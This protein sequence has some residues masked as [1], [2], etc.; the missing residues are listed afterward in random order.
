MCVKSYENLHPE[1]KEQLT[2]LCNK[3]E[4][5]KEVMKFVKKMCDSGKFNIAYRQK[6]LC[7]AIYRQIPCWHMC[8]PQNFNMLWAY[9]S[10]PGDPRIHLE[11]MLKEGEHVRLI[12]GR[13][14]DSGRPVIIKLYISGYKRS[15]LKS[16]SRTTKM[17]CD[18]YNKLGKPEPCLSTD[19]FIFGIPVL[20]MEVLAE[21]NGGDNEFEMGIQVLQQ[22]K[23]LHQFGVHCDLKPGNVMRKGDKYIVIDY[24]GVAT[25]KMDHGYRR[26]IW[27]PLW[28]SQKRKSETGHDIICTSKQDAIELGYTIKTL[29]NMKRQIPI[30][31]TRDGETDL[32][33]TGFEGKLAKYMKRVFEIDDI[34]GMTDKDRD[35]LIAILKC[36]CESCRKEEIAPIKL[37]VT[38]RPVVPR[39]NIQRDLITPS[40]KK[41]PGRKVQKRIR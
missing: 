6:I 26:W 25:E 19:Y 35:D 23:T 8:I 34:R 40:P 20:V 27:S 28:T 29:Q 17:E 7:Y 36:E 14:G 33:R 21:L 38:P 16:F 15:D 3:Y 18:I 39:V 24:G 32:I 9:S 4:T 12:R 41:K 13:M 5:S 22:L 1:L 37:Y 30:R 31:R 10:K 11:S 2:R